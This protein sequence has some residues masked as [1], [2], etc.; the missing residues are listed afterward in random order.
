MSLLLRQEDR[1]PADHTRN[2]RD[3]RNCRGRTGSPV[4]LLHP[5]PAH[6]GGPWDRRYRRPRSHPTVRARPA[7]PPVPATPRSTCRRRRG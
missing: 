5:S 4:H 2:H 1:L 3:R 6:P 7:D